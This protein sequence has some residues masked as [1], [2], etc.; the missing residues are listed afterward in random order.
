MILFALSSKSLPKSYDIVH[1]VGLFFSRMFS[2]FIEFHCASKQAIQKEIDVFRFFEK[3]IIQQN[4]KKIHHLCM[5]DYVIHPQKTLF[6]FFLR[7]LW[8]ISQQPAILFSKILQL[9][10]QRPVIILSKSTSVVFTAS[11]HS[12]FK[13]TWLISQRPGILF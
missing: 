4:D 9:I 8:L 13:N 12:F 1:L 6:F 2:R 5:Q 11:S 3:K 10:L 7:I